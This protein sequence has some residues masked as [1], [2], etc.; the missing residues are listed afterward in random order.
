M[1]K[2]FVLLVLLLCLSYCLSKEENIKKKPRSAKE[3]AKM[4]DSDINKMSKDIM[5]E[6]LDSDDDR[7]E[8]RVAQLTPEEK[9]K[10]EKIRKAKNKRSIKSKKPKKQPENNGIAFDAQGNPYLPKPIDIEELKSKQHR[11]KQQLMFAKIKPEYQGKTKDDIEP[12]TIRWKELLTTSGVDATLYNID[13]RTILFSVNRGQFSSDV[14][15]F[16]FEW[17]SQKY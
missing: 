5:L 13:H 9:E 2:F 16:A 15:K 8:E 14:K 4:T 12:L 1:R 10:F 6:D 17:D 7:F 11:N 3:W